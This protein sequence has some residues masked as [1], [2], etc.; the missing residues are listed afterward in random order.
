MVAGTLHDVD[1]AVRQRAHDTT[2]DRHF[3]LHRSGDVDRRGLRIEFVHVC[4]ADEEFFDDTAVRSKNAL[5]RCEKHALAR[6]EVFCERREKVVAT[7]DSPMLRT[8]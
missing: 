5:Y 1:L 4:F 8:I 2:G 3:A 7:V 6:L